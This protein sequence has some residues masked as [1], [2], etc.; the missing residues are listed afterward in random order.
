MSASDTDRLSEVLPQLLPRLWAFSLRLSG[1]RHDAERL[2]QSTCA[3]AIGRAHQL[4]PGMAP[5]SWI[6]AIAQSI[7]TSEFRP[8]A[9]AGW[10]DMQDESDGEADGSGHWPMSRQLVAAVE[11]LPETQRVV[12]LLTAV[13]GLS[14]TEAAQVLDV[15]VEMVMSQLSRARQTVGAKFRSESRSAGRVTSP[16]LFCKGAEPCRAVQLR[17]VHASCA[18]GKESGLT[19]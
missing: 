3:R 16:D 8:R 10:H 13:E 7:W 6:Y 18:K 19:C 9:R 5:L 2:L 11:S 4:R 14:Y 17:R 1:N 15:P 12:L